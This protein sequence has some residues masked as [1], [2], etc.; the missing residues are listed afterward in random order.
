MF[1]DNRFISHLQ[2]RTLGPEISRDIPF[3][4]PCIC[5]S[6][7]CGNYCVTKPLHVLMSWPEEH[8]ILRLRFLSF[9]SF[10]N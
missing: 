9:F 8:K 10:V 3:A 6:L 4:K 2:P 7:L 5:I 1:L